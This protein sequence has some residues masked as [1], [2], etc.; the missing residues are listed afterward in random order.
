[1]T[2]ACSALGSG[3]TGR[4]VCPGQ[5]TW[6]PHAFPLHTFSNKEM[7][8]NADV[9]LSLRLVVGL[10]VPEHRAAAL[11]QWAFKRSRCALDVRLGG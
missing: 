6:P 5:L 9:F 11:V 1:M 7:N 3:G 10:T 2:Y 8:M 4:C